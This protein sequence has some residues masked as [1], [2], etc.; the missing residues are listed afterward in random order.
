M[1]ND[2]LSEAKSL[3]D[4]GQIL[5]A[6]RIVFEQVAITRRPIWA[7]KAL[8]FA[9]DLT[10]IQDWIVSECI[11]ISECPGDWHLGK[12]LFDRIRDKVLDLERMKNRTRSQD[13]SLDVWLLAELVAKLAYNATDPADEFDD[14]TGWWVAVCLKYM[15]VD[16]NGSRVDDNAWAILTAECASVPGE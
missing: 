7:A 8:R 11:R 9:A 5:E 2:P 3:W 16:N 4:S 14:D 13:L 12:S 15:A 1:N 6:G 10:G